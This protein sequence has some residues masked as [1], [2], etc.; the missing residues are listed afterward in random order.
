MIVTLLAG[1]PAALWLCRRER[2][3]AVKTVEF[4]AVAFLLSGPW[5]IRNKLLY[6]EWLATSIAIG[7]PRAAFDAAHLLRVQT[8]H[9][10]MLP[11]QFWSGFESTFSR[12]AQQNVIKL[13]LVVGAVVAVVALRHWI[14]RRRVSAWQTER[15]YFWALVIASAG[16]LSGFAYYGWRYVQGEVRMLFPSLLAGAYLGLVPLYRS[17]HTEHHRKLTWALVVCALLPWIGFF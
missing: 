14:L 8:H 17:V 15:K 4:F 9:L 13:L 2:S 3:S 7:N 1:P 10:T 5:L 12:D 11:F 6:S 16:N